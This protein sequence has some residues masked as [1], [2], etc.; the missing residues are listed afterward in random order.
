[1]LCL[2]SKHEA[3]PKPKMRKAPSPTTCLAFLRGSELWCR[4]RNGQ[5]TEVD[6]LQVSNARV[7]CT[8]SVARS[9]S[10]LPKSQWSVNTQAKPRNSL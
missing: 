8:C 7:S 3:Q 4:F 9:V 1:M 6:A 2:D 10:V 5:V